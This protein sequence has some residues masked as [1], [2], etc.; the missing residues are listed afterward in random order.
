MRL[1][2]LLKLSPSGYFSAGNEVAARL[3]FHQERK[4]SMANPNF[5]TLVTTTLKNYRRLLAD[6]ITAHQILWFMLK[7]K[8][9]IKEEEGGTNIVEPLMIGRNTTVR[10]YSGYD[11]IDTTPQEGLSAAEYDWKQIA[12][13]VSISGR[14]EFINSGS[15][16]RILNLLESKI[17]QLQISMMLEVNRQLQAD[18]TG[19]GGKDLTGLAIAVEDGTA[20]STYGGIDS[21][22]FPYWRN[23]WIGGTTIVDTAAAPLTSSTSVGIQSFMDAMRTVYNS[24][25]RGKVKPTVIIS[26]QALYEAYEKSLV[27]NE[28]YLDMKLGDAGFQN[29]MY[30]NTPWVFDEDMPNNNVY[31][32]LGTDLINQELVMLNSDFMRFVLGKGKNF[33]VTDFQKPE[34]QD[35]KVSQVLFYGNLTVNNRAR[36]GRI[37]GVTIDRT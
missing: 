29:L 28:R 20:W 27:S 6:N 30:K 9:F 15:K 17:Q 25:S 12:G 22:A 35:A 34:N 7:E 19:N 11:I 24:A 5:D 3:T 16:T 32:P 37:S 21:N 13:S 36:Q 1:K 4:V 26:S 23:Q 33:V 8:G 10:S 18:G 2:P 31:P 14:E